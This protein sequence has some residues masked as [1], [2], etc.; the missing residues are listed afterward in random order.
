[1]GGNRD[2]LAQTNKINGYQIKNN[3]AKNK[4]GKKKKFIIKQKNKSIKNSQNDSI[5]ID[6]E[7]ENT[8]NNSYIASENK[9]KNLK[10]IIISGNNYITSREILEYLDFYDFSSASPENIDS[11]LKKLYQSDLFS[12]IKIYQS[13]QI[14]KIEVAENPIIADV[15]FIGSKK[16]EEKLLQNE[17][18]LKKKAIFTKGKLKSDLKRISEI[19][20]KSGRFLSYV[21]P[22]IKSR[23]NNLIEV[24]F[25]IFEGPKAD[26]SNINFIGN[27]NYSKSDL[28]SAISTKESKW[29]RFFSS[30]DSFDSDRIDFD[31]ENLRRFYGNR[32]Y[33]DFTVISANSQLTPNK[34]NFFINFVIE[35]GIKYRINN[36]T[37]NNLVKKFD[38]TPLYKKILIKK[39]QFY[40]L[41][42]IDKTIDRMIEFMSEK[43]FAF[44]HIEPKLIRNKEQKTIDIEFIIEET[45]PIYINK[46]TIS[47]NS[48]T[49]DEVIRRE[50]RIKEGDPYNINKINR[51]RQRIENLGFFEKVNLN[52]KRIDNSD[53]VDIE[54]EVKEKKTGEF[55]FGVGYSTVD[56]LTTN[57]GIRERNVAGTSQELGLNLQKSRFTTSADINYVKPYFYGQ[58]IDLGIDVFK[59]DMSKRNTL[60]YDQSSSGF[61]LKGDYAISEFL[62][63]QIRYSFRDETVSNVDSAASQNIRN[64]Q[65]N[66]TSSIFGHSFSYDKRNNRIDPRS[67]YFLS[68]SQ[69]LSKWGGNV[70]NIKY[71]GSATYYQP[72]FNDDFILK[73]ITRAGFIDGIGQD[74]RSNYGF[75]LGGNNFRGFEFGGIGPRT[76]I[77]G[78]AKNGDILGGNIYYIG[79]AEFR[80]PLGLPKELGIYG[81]L[82]SDNGTVTKTDK[83][84]LNGNDVA[85][86]GSLRSSYG[87][88]LAWSSPMGPIRLDFSRIYRKEY[89]DRTQAFRFSFGSNF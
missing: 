16:I 87:L 33:A 27:K 82:F 23:D 47:G 53:K 38:E 17:L 25:E 83:I 39:K 2:A 41:E 85:D 60:V 43:S 89:F 58:N 1:M 76:K 70:H 66:F 37:I 6:Q 48:R 32:G 30:D 34:S 12:D 52:V 69:D 84:N 46:I 9:S 4:N 11:S 63:H 10:E 64:L 36:I 49:L 78:N 54:I 18:S 57:I 86:T 61:A 88:S 77:N 72:T 14:V 40:N 75:F 73:F 56:M 79:T 51:S 44:A 68:F 22:K 31:K 8:D 80:F 65:G 45:P 62:R 28:L 20:L 50:I 42:M 67:G 26:I 74:V 24:I 13:D 5:E 71:E 29:Y 21:E 35:E 15:K 19:Y 59:Y 3:A 81:I 55:N 7:L